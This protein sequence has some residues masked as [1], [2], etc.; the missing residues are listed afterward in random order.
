MPLDPS[1]FSHNEA[2]LL[3]QLNRV[4]VRTERDGEFNAMA[5][6]EV[7]TGMIFG[8][9]LVQIRA[10]CMPEFQARKLLAAAEHEARCRP[11][12]LFVGAECD[13]DDFVRIATAMGIEVQRVPGVELAEV[14]REAIE[15]F[16][17]HVSGTQ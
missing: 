7:A 2:W 16:A 5:I 6:M 8:I 11:E 14:T 17:T 3:F 15:G 9:Q 1:A 4:P 10:A 13:E 12:R